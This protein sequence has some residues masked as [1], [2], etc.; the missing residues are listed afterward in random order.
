M[1]L[2]GGIRHRSDLHVEV[3]MSR[4]EGGELTSENFAFT[5]YGTGEHEQSR[6]R[7]LN[8]G[9][10]DQ[11]HSEHETETEGRRVHQANVE[12]SH[13]LARRDHM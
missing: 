10:L 7:L 9:Q 5:A 12:A 1:L 13:R 4:L 8:T 6:G 11:E 3:G 2:V